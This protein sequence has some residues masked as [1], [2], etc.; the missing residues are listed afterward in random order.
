MT[1]AK[2]MIGRPRLAYFSPMPPLKNGVSTLS[3]DLIPF[4]GVHYDID[5]IVDQDIFSDAWSIVNTNIIDW[6]EFPERSSLY[7]RIVYH[8]GDSAIHAYMFDNLQKYPGVVVLHDFFLANV[9]SHESEIAPAHQNWMSNAI[10]HS[11]GWAGYL[12]YRKSTNVKEEIVSAY[13]CNLAVLQNSIGTIVH[14]RHT[15]NLA[16]AWYGRDTG[17]DW[18]QVPLLRNPF[19]DGQRG[20][21]RQILNIAPDEFVVC[22]FGSLNPRKFNE[23]LLKV[24]LASPLV[25]DPF[26]RLVFVGENDADSYDQGLSRLI[27]R[28]KGASRIKITGWADDA[29]YQSWLKATDVG[30]QLRHSSRGEMPGTALDC[31]SH[32]LATIVNAHGALADLP[33]DK[34]WMLDDAFADEDLLQALMTLHQDRDRRE[35]LGASARRYVRAEHNPRT[36]AAAYTAAI[37]EFYERA[38]TGRLGAIQALAKLDLSRED[39]EL[40][41]RALIRNLP[42]VPRQRQLLLDVSE[43]IRSDKRTGIERVVRALAREMLLAPPTGW[44]VELVYG[45]QGERGYRYARDFTARLLDVEPLEDQDHP[46]DVWR[47]DRFLGLDWCP[48]VNMA[49]QAMF[50]LWM[51]RGVD[52]Q[53]I[54][55]DLLPVRAPQFFPPGTDQTFARWLEWI[56]RYSGVVCISRATADDYLDFLEKAEVKR[57]RPLAVNWAHIGADLSNSLPSRGMPPDAARILAEIRRRPTFLMVGTIEP[58]KGHLRALAAF[59]QLWRHGVDVNLVIIGH[60][61]WKPVPK[62]MRRTIPEIVTRLRSNPE[63]GKRLFWLEGISDEY[64][65][66]IYDTATCLLATSE[67]EGFGLPLVEA[68]QHKLPVIA[69][70]LPV[71]H[72][73]AGDA[74]FYVPAD[75]RPESLA[76]G[77]TSWLAL[78]EKGRAPSSS[79]MRW[80]NW[81]ESAEAYW[82]VLEGERPYRQWTSSP[83]MR[84]KA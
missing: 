81:Q 18:A 82:A 76:A 39:R 1:K 23:K 27:A 75:A 54:L 9:F 17:S 4:L 30:V 73:V 5:V 56:A 37:E 50:D 15:I 34:V 35:A 21:A 42:P 2:G 29:T 77:V 57:Q 24:W 63:L 72:E 31:M 44:R 78:H 84:K 41:H 46:V 28:H 13:P 71:F 69:C 43:I 10:L 52:V 49:N 67:G 16:Q 25:D 64:L 3:A 61:G 70:D 79:G 58:R 83:V 33:A 7:D 80:L 6:R 45:R 48:D 12:D 32:G 60:E 8:F 47:G 66:Q 20:T 65:E 51:A 26:C 36:C 14:S 40:A 11:H 55:Y 38:Q 59:D 74:A 19:P 68:A 62:D 22:S 53:F